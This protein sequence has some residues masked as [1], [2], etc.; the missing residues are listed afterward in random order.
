MVPL[1]LRFF[2]LLGC[3]AALRQV[4][5]ASR[6]SWHKGSNERSNEILEFSLILWRYRIQNLTV[7]FFINMSNM[8]QSTVDAWD[9]DLFV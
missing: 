3:A 4:E 1:T 2:L 9:T 6:V 7:Y 8:F 5:D